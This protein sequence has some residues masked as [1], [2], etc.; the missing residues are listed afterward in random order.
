MLR[1][2]HEKKTELMPGPF[3][4]GGAIFVRSILNGPDETYQKARLFAHTT[5][6]PNSAIVYHIHEG[7]SETYYI[8]SG[9]GK[10]ND[11]G[12]IKEVGPGDVLFTGAGEGHGLETI[13]DEPINLV[14]VVF[15]Q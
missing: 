2:S 10:F 13:G 5:V 9:H 4:G 7:E 8:V 3:D 14:A 1:K 12:T 11:N 15:Y 6:Y